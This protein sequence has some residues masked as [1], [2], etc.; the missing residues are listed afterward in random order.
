MKIFQLIAKYFCKKKIA[1]NSENLFCFRCR[2]DDDR[3]SDSGV[4]SFTLIIFC[5]FEITQVEIRSQRKILKPFF[6][7]YKS[8]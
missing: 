1:P 3:V 6:D 2:M 8:R 4:S 7:K 5:N